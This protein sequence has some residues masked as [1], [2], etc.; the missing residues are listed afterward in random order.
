MA[1][2]FRLWNPV[3]TDASDGLSAI[4]ESYQMGLENFT[5]DPRLTLQLQAGLKTSP[6]ATTKRQIT[7]L[8]TVSAGTKN[9]LLVAP[10]STSE[11]LTP[12][13]ATAASVGVASG[14]AVAANT[15]RRGLIL[16]NTSANRI[17]LAFGAA[18]VLDSGIT[19]MANGGTYTMDGN[20]FTTAEI[21][22]IASGAASNLAIQEFS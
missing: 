14:V 18:A 21:R 5:F 19:L 17:S 7:A 15:S 12:A 11:S 20:S 13:T 8:N 2:P 4:F 3:G 10:I 22:A 6:D 1:N 9:A 16:V